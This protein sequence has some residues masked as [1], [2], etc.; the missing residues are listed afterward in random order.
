MKLNVK[1]FCLTTGI[2]WAAAVLLVGIAN[3]IWSGYGGAFLQLIA[4]IYPGYDATRSF[5]A[6]I[7]GTLYALLDGFV[8][9]LV[10]AL[11]YN[12]IA[13]RPRAAA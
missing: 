12:L 3:L 4:S 2:L 10:F 11:V 5:G 13:G 8:L 1:A 9:G 7:V 6:V